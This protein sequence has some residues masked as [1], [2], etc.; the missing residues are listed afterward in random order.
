MKTKSVQR[1]ILECVSRNLSMQKVLD[2]IY[3]NTGIGT[4]IHGL[5][6]G[7]I[8]HSSR[9]AYTCPP[10]RQA[11]AKG[12]VRSLLARVGGDPEKFQ[13]LF[14]IREPILTAVSLADAS[15]VL[16]QPILINGT[17]EG[18]LLLNLPDGSDEAAATGAAHLLVE[19]YAYMALNRQGHA[20]AKK[21]AL[22]LLITRS[23][24]LSGGGSV[25]SLIADYN[26]AAGTSAKGRI[27][28]RPPYAI[29]V[30][31]P[32]D[33]RWTA[34]APDD[35]LSDLKMRIR[36]SFSAMIKENLFLFL[37][38]LHRDMQPMLDV[39]A[40]VASSNSMLCG[41]SSAFSNLDERRQYKTQAQD[42]IIVGQ[43]TG[44]PFPIYRAADLYFEI[45][46]YKAMEQQGLTFFQREEISLL[47]KY[48]VENDTDYMRTLETYLTCYNNLSQAAGCMYLDRSTLR[49]RLLKIK[50]IMG[51]DFDEPIIARQLQAGILV[52]QYISFFERSN[53]YH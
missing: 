2:E 39:L 45:L 19:T 15:R 17:A 47:E 48:D 46:V 35:I 14:K 13:E 49:Y 33:S 28:I 31:S 12:N 26:L 10:W 5:G 38:G 4:I 21:G 53:V 52:S 25:G 1:I 27:P 3:E 43:A 18:G 44:K 42:A 7:I 16:F 51:I 11:V 34:D 37:F 50:S 30:L 36:N 32:S 20:G 29:A 23:L 6:L 9:L 24:L 8:L 40:D 22:D 41:I